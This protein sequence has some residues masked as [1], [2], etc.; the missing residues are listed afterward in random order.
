MTLTSKAVKASMLALLMIPMLSSCAPA[1]P[2]TAQDALENSFVEEDEATA[3]LSEYA[4]NPDRTLEDLVIEAAK[5]VDEAAVLKKY[6]HLDPKKEVAANLLK[7]ALLYFDANPSRFPNKAYI[8]IVD[9]SIKSRKDRFFLINMKTGAVEKFH[10]AH[11]SKSDKDGD[12]IPETFSNIVDSNMSSLGVYR[13]SE[14]YQSSKFG[15]SMRLDGLSSTNSNV[16]KRAIVLHRAWYVWEADTIAPGKTY[17]C[18]GLS[19]SVTDDVIAKLKNG[20][21]IYAGLSAKK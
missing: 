5:P 19:K 3:A 7:T 12:G 21:L 16:R 20:S 2:E 9:F 18:F 14:P 11:G 10:V 1:N 6:K 8:A 13:A 4:A 17:G 15:Y